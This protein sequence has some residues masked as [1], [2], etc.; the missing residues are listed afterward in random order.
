FIVNIFYEDAEEGCDCL[1][2]TNNRT[3]HV[4]DVGGIFDTAGFPVK[5]LAWKDNYTLTFEA[6]RDDTD[7]IVQYAIDV[8]TM[9]LV[10]AS[11]VISSAPDS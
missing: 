1:F 9:K 10:R 5:K 2:F 3:G 4:Y 8:R 6:H 11:L 7:N